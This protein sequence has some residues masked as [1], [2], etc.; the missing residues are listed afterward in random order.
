MDKNQNLYSLGV[1]A[2]QSCFYNFNPANYTSLDGYDQNHIFSDKRFKSLLYLANRAL[3][4]FTRAGGIYDEKMENMHSFV[5]LKQK[6]KKPPVFSIYGYIAFNKNL[7]DFEESIIFCLNIINKQ[8]ELD[9]SFFISQDDDA[10][11]D[12]I[13]LRSALMNE[14]P[15]KDGVVIAPLSFLASNNTLYLPEHLLSVF[16]LWKIDRVITAIKRRQ[17]SDTAKLLLDAVLSINES[18]S[19]FDSKIK[20]LTQKKEFRENKSKLGQNGPEFQ[21]EL[22]EQAIKLYW[23][24]NNGMPWR[25]FKRAAE[26]IY[27]TLKKREPDLIKNIAEKS[28]VRTM[29][30]WLQQDDPNKEFS[31]YGKKVSS[32]LASAKEF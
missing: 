25:S 15:N 21:R 9:N 23:Q 14:T 5:S 31:E 2:G 28:A 26:T 22:K 32:Q 16:A 10:H 13:I 18:Q 4:F 6:S 1:E 8:K 27:E 12:F 17:A 29:T 30:S 20:L 19:L 3:V 7:K 11:K 24:G